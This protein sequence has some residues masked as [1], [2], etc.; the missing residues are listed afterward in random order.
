MEYTHLGRSGLKVSK[1]CLGTMNF[2]TYTSDDDS[3]TIMDKALDLGINFFDTAN[4][5][6]Y[7]KSW[8]YTEELI[9]NWFMQGNGRRDKVVLATKVYGTIDQWPNHSKLSALHIKRACEDSLRRLKTDYIDLYQMHHI[10]RDT[11]WEEIWQ[12]MDQL[13][14]EGKIIYVGSSNFAAWNLVQANCKAEKM[15]MLGL[16]SEQSIYNLRNRH[17]ELEVIP[18]CKALGIGLI[19]WSPL[20]GGILCGISEEIKEGRRARP[21]L[22][23]SFKRLRSQVESYERICEE[24]ELSCANIALAWVLHNPVVA[25]P[26]VGPRTLEQL[27]ESCVVLKHKLSDEMAN[28]LD[29]IWPGPGNQAPEAYAW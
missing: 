4:G 26:I 15:N 13:I 21:A 20:G 8:G 14:T 25:S 28:K 3:F 29:E 1:L 11:P 10:D 23:K 18:A 24:T 2:G 19:P 27:E 7:E 22:Q 6:G 9:G 5:Y 16:I 12:A 17:I